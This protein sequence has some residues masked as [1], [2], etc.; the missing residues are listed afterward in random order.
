VPGFTELV[1][2]RRAASTGSG[3]GNHRPGNGGAGL[4][5]ASTGGGTHPAAN[6][7]NAAAAA[8]QPE[9]VSLLGS[10]LGYKTLEQKQ[11]AVTRNWEN[12]YRGKKNF[13]KPANV[14]RKY[15]LTKE[16]YGAMVK[17]V[18]AQ[19][20]ARFESKGARLPSLANLRPPTAGQ[21]PVPIVTPS[22]S[23]QVSASGTRSRISSI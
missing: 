15:G 3:A 11:E 22:V 18:S 7:K 4:R 12:A 20:R 9:T 8:A 14:Q 19:A 23:R 16:Q 17:E 13:P 21:G 6:K 2:A 10:L 5:R 1:Q